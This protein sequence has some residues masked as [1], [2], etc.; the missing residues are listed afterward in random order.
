M[1]FQK[2]STVG[3]TPLLNALYVTEP[4]RDTVALIFD[5]YFVFISSLFPDLGGQVAHVGSSD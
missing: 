2:G 1:R 3:T 4:L 5:F